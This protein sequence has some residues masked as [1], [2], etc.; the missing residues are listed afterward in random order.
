[1]AMVAL[2]SMWM[3]GRFSDAR[4]FFAA[5]RGM[6]FWSFEISSMQ[7]GAFYDRIH[8][9]DYTIS[10]FHDP[11]PGVLNGRVRG[12]LL[13][14]AADEEE[15]CL[16]VATTRRAID[17]ARR[18]AAQAVVLHLGASAADAGLQAELERLALAGEGASDAAQALRER[19]RLSRG[20]GLAEMAALMRSLD[21]LIPY[22]EKRDIRLGF[23]NRRHIH[24]MPNFEEMQT[25]LAH[26]PQRTVGYW[27]DTGH[28][29][30]QARAG[31]TPHADWLRTF[32]DRLVGMHLHDLVISSAFSD[33][34]PPG[35]GVVDWQ[36]LGK[37]AP[38]TGL[39]TLEVRS[40]T[41]PAAIASAIA[42]LL[43]LGWVS[44]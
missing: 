30:A 27:H 15:R 21:E 31:L 29:E 13:L 24:E 25:L 41:E 1:M 37:L 44:P 22:A 39:R 20:D 34:E 8:P 23:E 17:V 4:E 42:L 32:G 35:G 28:A 9:G 36:G 26:Y 14:N 6:G 38:Q 7:D 43:A 3:R 16:A 2:S 18:F 40:H 12:H 10:S 19:L 33:H 11:A 5:G